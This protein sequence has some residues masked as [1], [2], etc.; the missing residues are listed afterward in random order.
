MSKRSI[1]LSTTAFAFAAL[2]AAN[3]MAQAPGSALE[4]VVVTANKRVENV[5]DVPKQVQVVTSVTLKEQNI[6]SV[7]DLSKLV[8]SL[9][10]TGNSL[11]IRGVATGATC[12]NVFASPLRASESSVC[13]MSSI[14]ATFSGYSTQYP[15]V[16]IVLSGK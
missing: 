16:C 15:A 9:T 6:S 1:L 11:G 10:G 2:T 14:S 3:A 12:R 8:P 7:N 5:Q 13:L 4:E